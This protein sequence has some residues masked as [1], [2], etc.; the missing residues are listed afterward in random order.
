MTEQDKTITW[1]LAL[2]LLS[3]IAAAIIWHAAGPPWA[4]TAPVLGALVAP[5]Q[6]TAI[7]QRGDKLVAC[8]LPRLRNFQWLAFALQ[9]GLMG[10]LL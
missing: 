10:V 4:F 5:F 6:S 1:G 7:E 3:I 9:A 8:P 2:I